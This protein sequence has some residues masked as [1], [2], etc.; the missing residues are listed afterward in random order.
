MRKFAPAILAAMAADEIRAF[1]LLEMD[2]DGTVYKH[3][4]CDVPIRARGVRYTPYPFTAKPL[5]YDSNKIVTSAQITLDI[6]DQ[7]YTTLFVGGT[8]Q[9]GIVTLRYVFLDTSYAVISNPITL[10]IGT[11]DKWSLTETTIKITVANELKTWDKKTLSMHPSS[12]RWKIFGGTECTYAGAETWC[13]RSYT[14]CTALGNTIHFGGFRWL[15]SIEDKE[16]WWG[17]VQKDS[18]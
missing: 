12:C 13:D 16:V 11:L 5:D 8:P 14:R 1:L 2:L 9:P 4:T 15:P 17:R 10:F 18:D 7:T 3:T 6:T